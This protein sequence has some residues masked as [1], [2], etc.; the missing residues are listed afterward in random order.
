M[1]RQKFILL[2][3]LLLPLVTSGDVRIN[4]PQSLLAQA[5]RLAMLYNWPK[6]A[7]LYSQAESLFRRSGDPKNALAAR[8]GY[9]WATADWGVHRATKREVEAYLAD[10]LVST[11]PRLRLRAL[12]AKAVLDRNENEQTARGPWK[13]ILE[14]ATALGD[15][16]WEGRA[17]AEVGQILYMDGNIKSAAAVLRDAIVSQ[18]LHLDFGA[19]VQYTAM[20]GNGFVETGQPEAG[21]QYCNIVLRTSYLVPDLGFPFLAYQGKARALFALHRDA[22]AATVLDVALKRAREEHN[23]FALAQLLIVAGT[24]AA[25]SGPGRAIQGLKEANEIS[26]KNGFQHVYAWG[27]IEL[28]GAYR[29]VGDLDG[30]ERVASKAIEFMRDLEDVYHLPQDL[31]LL[32]DLESKKGNFDRADQ[33]YSE[34]TDVMNGLLVNV[35]RRQVKSSLIATLSD[36]Y[37]GH[38]ELAATQLSDVGKAYEIIEEARGRALA[39]TLQGE[40]ESLSSSSDEITIDA[41]KEITRIQL[42]LMHESSPQARQLLLDQLFGTEQLL[43]P[44]AKVHSALDSSSDHR[45]GVPIHTIQASLRE[46]EMLLE[47]VMGESQSYCLRITRTASEIVVLRA[48][49][50]AIEK[51]VDD[52][53]AAVRSRQSKITAGAELFALLLQPAITKDRKPRLT[54]VPDGKLHLLPFDGLTDQNGKYVLESHIVTYAPSATVLHLLRQSHFR[55]KVAMSFLGVGDVIYPRSAVVTANASGRATT[56]ENAKTDFFDLEG[57]T[58][59]ELPG[60]RQEVVGV[61]SLMTGEKRVLLDKHATEAEFKGLPLADFRVIHLAVHGLGNSEFP[62]RAALVLGGS[63]NIGQ[64]GLLQ[65]REIRD[66]PL[67]ADLVTLSAC[68][69]GNGKLLGEE[70]IASL[71]RAFLLAGAKSVIASLWTADDTYSIALMK[72]LYQHLIDGYDKGAA[73]RQAKVDLLKEFAGQAVP[74]YWAGFTLVG[75]GATAITQ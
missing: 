66:L 2:I 53:L 4:G 64:D 26:E 18:Y 20:V 75:E 57:V 28:A 55:D 42:A 54:I 19:A 38:F 52:Y 8:L 72:R 65:V 69:T 47:Y 56:K 31:A 39:D 44:E 13:Q 11:D 5:D 63:P 48:S 10:P 25:L 32:A 71:E 37:V 58:F 3:P 14:L 59:P 16:R 33:L 73:L 17:K 49:R 35:V 21:L 22:E 62:D 1:R 43:S 41:N 40:S 51:L 30:A 46:D 36:A 12:V 60:S 9:I 50:K 15:R 45:K 23:H 74:V 27:A 34:A 67:R 61:A 24:G 70:G 68:D 29:N 6:A 7:P